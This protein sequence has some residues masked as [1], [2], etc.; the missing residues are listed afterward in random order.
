MEEEDE[1][2]IVDKNKLDND[3]DCER[4]PEGKG[5]SEIDCNNSSSAEINNGAQYNNDDNKQ[6]TEHEREDSKISDLTSGLEDC[7]LKW[8]KA[9]LK[10]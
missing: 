10:K 6:K 2:D 7:K 1:D 8:I 4:L 5:N 3:L 9:G